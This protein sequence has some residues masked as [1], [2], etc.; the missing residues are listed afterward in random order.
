MGYVCAPVASQQPGWPEPMKRRRVYIMSPFSK[1]PVSGSSPAPFLIDARGAL[2][3]TPATGRSA[4]RSSVGAARRTMEGLSS[5]IRLSFGN[6]DAA[7]SGGNFVAVT[8]EFALSGADD[9]RANST[10]DN[11][12]NDLAPVDSC[13]EW[14]VPVYAIRCASHNAIPH[15]AATHRRG[16]PFADQPLAARQE[17]AR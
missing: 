12:V 4:V 9:W 1:L 6:D 13:S 5:C 7:Q 17:N 16:E 14:V 3:S 8:F 10:G 15:R 2:P 11:A